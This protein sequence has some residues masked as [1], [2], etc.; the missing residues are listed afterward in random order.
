MRPILIWTP[1][2][3][4]GGPGRA[5][6]RTHDQ[7][8]VFTGRR[9]IN[10]T[11]SPGNSFENPQLL[12]YLT[13]PN[14]LVWSAASASCALP[15]LY[16]SVQLMAKN[17]TGEIVPY[18]VSTVTWTDGSLEHDLPINRSG[19]VPAFMTPSA[20]VGARARLARARACHT[21]Y[22]LRLGA[23]ASARNPIEEVVRPAYLPCLRPAADKPSS[24]ML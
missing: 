3:L 20:C 15:G 19:D 18:H 1:S 5:S 10:I 4:I 21:A 6:L 22:G 7:R 9:I 12:N 13:A 14:V 8:L 24:R 2:S 16:E 11:V 23:L 17:Q